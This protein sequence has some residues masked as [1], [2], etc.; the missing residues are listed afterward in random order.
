[1]TT[2]VS[3]GSHAHTLSSTLSPLE[4]ASLELSALL[5]ELPHAATL[6]SIAAAPVSAT[7]FFPIVNFIVLYLLPYAA[8]WR[9][10]KCLTLPSVLFL[11]GTAIE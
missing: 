8:V 3:V 1:M 7:T 4:D 11:S 10:M 6:T 2:W 9:A 5:L